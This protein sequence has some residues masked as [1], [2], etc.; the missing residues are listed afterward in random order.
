NIQGNVN[1]AGPV[2]LQ[3]A[4]KLAN[5]VVDQKVCV[6]V[7]RQVQNKRRL[8]N[9]PRDNHVQQPPHNK[10]NV[11]KAYTAGPGKKREYAG[12]LPP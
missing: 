4:I 1:S 11:A 10:Q 7:A 3:D 12:S 9:N 6:F 5:I 2:R 8:K